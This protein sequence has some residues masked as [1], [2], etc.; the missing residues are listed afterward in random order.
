MTQR[1]ERTKRRWSTAAMLFGCLILEIPFASG[2]IK[3]GD[4]A[5]PATHSARKSIGPDEIP[6]QLEGRWKVSLCISRGHTWIR[7]Q[8][9]KTGEVRSISRYH[10]LVGSAY[11]LRHLKWIHRPTMQTGLYMD[12]ERLVDDQVLEGKCLMLSTFVDDP[13]IFQHDESH[14][15]G[16]VV[17]NCV[18]YARDAWHFYTGEWYELPPV[19]APADLLRGV[20]IRHPEAKRR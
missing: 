4:G 11:D 10:L 14:G 7:Y 16:I 18:T 19:H 12:R 1:V 9:L 8:N 6:E 2:F 17:N 15:H 20:L 5:E 3:A 13:V